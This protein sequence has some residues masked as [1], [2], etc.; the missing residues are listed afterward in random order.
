MNIFC[1]L[2]AKLFIAAWLIVF[3]IIIIETSEQSDVEMR[4]AALRE[5]L[6]QRKQ[7]AER[8]Q[9][10]QKR[11]RREKLKSKELSLINQI[12]VYFCRHCL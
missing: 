8:L 9:K 11:A 12:Q 5:Q 1:F 7:E 2:F 3:F 4:I 10:E 6:K